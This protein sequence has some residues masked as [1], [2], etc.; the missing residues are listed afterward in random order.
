MTQIGFQGLADPAVDRS[1]L[2]NHPCPE[3]LS[4][5]PP[6]GENGGDRLDRPR[7]PA[8][9]GGY[10]RSMRAINTHAEPHGSRVQFRYAIL[11]GLS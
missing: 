5:L 4:A 10:Q 8:D 6:G 3:R 11:L 7:S 1:I 2:Q 9:T